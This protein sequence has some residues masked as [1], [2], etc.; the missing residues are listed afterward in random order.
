MGKSDKIKVSA[1]VMRANLKEDLMW[2]AIQMPGALFKFKLIYS[3]DKPSASID[4]IIDNLTLVQLRWATIQVANTLGKD[5][6]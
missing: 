3:N 2:L 1:K 4:V 5:K 6:K